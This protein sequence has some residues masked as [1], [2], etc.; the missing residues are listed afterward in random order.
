MKNCT[1]AEYEQNNNGLDPDRNGKLSVEYWINKFGVW[2]QTCL[3]LKHM[4]P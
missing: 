2:Q 3:S 4:L 1:N